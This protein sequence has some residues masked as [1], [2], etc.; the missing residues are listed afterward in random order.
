MVP[1]FH[2][3]ISHWHP[4]LAALLNEGFTVLDGHRAI[5]RAVR[6]DQR[7]QVLG[8]RE[9]RG[10]QRAHMLGD[11]RLPP[12]CDG[13]TEPLHGRQVVDI[14]PL[15]HDIAHEAPARVLVLQVSV[16]RKG[17]SET[18]LLAAEDAVDL[19]ADLR[20][21]GGRH[22]HVPTA[23]GRPDPRRR[24]AHGVDGQDGPG[25]GVPE[26]RAALDGAVSAAAGTGDDEPGGVDQA[27]D[28][29]VE[30]ARHEGVGVAQVLD[31]LQTRG[32]GQD[33]VVRGDERPATLQGGLDEPARDVLAV[34]GD[35][36]K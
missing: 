33:A 2:A 10:E 4:D 25:D 3:E 29:D 16:R 31:E 30:G 1:P 11:G 13:S 32:L 15:L 22:V 28:L 6:H 27:G 34:S 14:Q 18:D 8:D 9:V 17:L 19:R 24:I 12:C 21:L 7:R 26:P 20:R 5:D 23:L 36:D 35:L